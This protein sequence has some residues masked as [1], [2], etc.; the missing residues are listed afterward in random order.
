MGKKKH[1]EEY[2]VVEVAEVGK[3]QDRRPV[4][5]QFLVLRVLA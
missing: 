2:L 4:T 1:S 5:P 3:V